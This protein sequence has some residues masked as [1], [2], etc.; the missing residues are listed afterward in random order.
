[1]KQLKKKVPALVL[2]VGLTM[3]PLPS[4]SAVVAG[5]GDDMGDD[6]K[7]VEFTYHELTDEPDY[8]WTDGNVYYLKD[9]FIDHVSEMKIVDYDPPVQLD[10]FSSPEWTSYD[11]YFAA[12]DDNTVIRVKI[13]I[14]KNQVK[15]GIPDHHLTIMYPDSIVYTGNNEFYEY[16]DGNQYARNTINSIIRAGDIRYPNQYLVAIDGIPWQSHP[17]KWRIIESVKRDPQSAYNLSGKGERIYE[18][19][20]KEGEVNLHFY[21]HKSYALINT[22]AVFDGPQ[23][24]S[25]Q[26]MERAPFERNGVLYVPLH[27]IIRGLGGRVEPSPKDN[28]YKVYLNDKT[29]TVGKGS[30]IKE[31]GTLMVDINEL[32]KMGYKI[33]FTD[34]D[35]DLQRVEIIGE[36]KNQDRLPVLEEKNFALVGGIGNLEKVKTTSIAMDFALRQGWFTGTKLNQPHPYLPSDYAEDYRENEP[37]KRSQFAVLLVRALGVDVSNVTINTAFKDMQGHWAAKELSYAIAKQWLKGYK[38]GTI[39]PENHLT[40]AQLLTILQRAYDIPL[41]KGK[42]KYPNH[43]ANDVIYTFQQRGWIPDNFSP[44]EKV[45][46]GQAAWYLHK[47]YNDL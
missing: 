20:P 30:T 47:L 36:K 32:K 37:L 26:Y 33:V 2:A 4:Y 18:Y 34:F 39:K 25:A 43:W 42:S 17:L 35:N 10:V 12:D 24:A 19:L 27:D 13:P 1:M 23:Y 6:D 9:R 28:V 46:R 16:D 3:L 7:V 29:Y 45:T 21:R 15:D 44:E 22:F 8:A 31:Q 41:V 40:H 14:P 11:A 5:A 38:D